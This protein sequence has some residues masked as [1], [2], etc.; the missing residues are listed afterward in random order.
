MEMVALMILCY[1]PL[2]RLCLYLQ[3][4]HHLDSKS[5]YRQSLPFCLPA[6][7]CRDAHSTYK[8]LEVHAHIRSRSYKICSGGI[9]FVI[10]CA[11]SSMVKT[12][13]SNSSR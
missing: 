1:Q 8:A 12:C 10:S 3:P 2:R 5:D 6:E 7:V 11:C 9:Q 13:G 4:L